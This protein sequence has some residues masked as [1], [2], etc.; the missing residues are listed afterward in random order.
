MKN[1]RI[2]L[3]ICHYNNLDGLSRSIQSIKEGFPIDILIVDD[4]SKEKPDLTKLQ[5]NYPSG[6]IILEILPEN[7]GVGVATNVGLKK[8]LEMGYEFT[9]RLD[10][11]DLVYP[12]KFK[13]QLD[14]LDSHLDVKLL[15]TWVNIV[16]MNGNSVFV[17]KHP[18][19]Y[20]EIK[21]KIYL[22]STFVNSSTIFYTEILNTTGLYPDKYKRNGEDYAFFFNVVEKCK[23][24][25]L[26]EVLLDYEINPNSLSTKGRKNQVRAR[27]S[28]MKEHFKWG[29]YPIYGIIRSCVLLFMSRDATTFLKKRL[30]K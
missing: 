25:N 12:E 29:F 2:I 28:I 24:E 8:I 26:P 10:C 11:G 16:D 13:K 6:K 1:P 23:C 19:T 15:G 18:V 30:S 21:K 20:P 22:N 7:K 5:D 4:G 14:Y 27:L 9:G 3:L 17:L